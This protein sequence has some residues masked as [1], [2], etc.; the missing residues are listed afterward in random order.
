[1]RFK[2]VGAQLAIVVDEFGGTSGV[3]TLTDILEAIVGDIPAAGEPE[4]P[5]IVRRP[6]GSLLVDG[7][8]PLEELREALGVKQLPDEGEYQTL[9]GFVLH[10][11][12]RVPAPGDAFVWDGRHFEVLDMDG[13]RIDKVLIVPG[14]RDD[15]ADGVQGASGWTG[16]GGGEP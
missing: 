8:V 4:E 11:L 3:I 6:D 9:A 5:P 15:T 13:R 12:Q 7:L 14:S 10:Q 2:Q 1:M 16:R